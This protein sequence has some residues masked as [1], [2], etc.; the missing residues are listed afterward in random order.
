MKIYIEKDKI[1]NHNV[2]IQTAHQGKMCLSP[3]LTEINALNFAYGVK[4]GITLAQSEN[5]IVEIVDE[6]QEA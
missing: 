1:N 2:W 5:P 3:P 4:A 6:V